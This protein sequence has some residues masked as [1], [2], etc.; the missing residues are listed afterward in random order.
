MDKLEA[1]KRQLEALRDN[2]KLRAEIAGLSLPWWRRGAIVTGLTA[3]LSG[4]ATAATG[5]SAHFQSQRETALKET[6]QRHTAAMSLQ[7]L[8]EDVRANYLDR[9]RDEEER[10]RT[11]RFLIATADDDKVKGWAEKEKVLVDR[12]VA[13]LEK[14]IVDLEG[15]QKQADKLA[16]DALSRKQAD[17][18]A[19]RIKAQALAAEKQALEARLNA[20]APAAPVRAP[21]GQAQ[22]VP[23]RVEMVRKGLLEVGPH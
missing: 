3:I 5:I 17:A 10:Q 21:V 16:Q 1:E 4:A 23:A 6:E 12:E 20:P 11:L 18:D 19:Y 15:L 8:N 7:K 14:R 13:A 22:L 2:A 9:M